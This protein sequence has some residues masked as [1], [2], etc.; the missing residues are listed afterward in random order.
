[1]KL[2]ALRCPACNHSLA[3]ENEHVVVSC[4]RCQA[5]VHISD[6]GLTQL[7][8]TYAAPRN[9]VQATDWLPF[10]VFEG[11]VNITRRTTQGGGSEQAAATRLW[12]EPRRL[13]VPAWELLLNQAQSIGSDMIQRQPSFQPAP[14]PAEARLTPVT[15]APQDALNVL[16]FIVLAIEARRPDWLKSLDFDLKVDEPALW[17]LPARDGVV[18]ALK[19]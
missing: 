7:S 11:R 4:E 2:L 6:E 5:A 19:E 10:W 3:P 1:M 18:V 12:G 8:V 17:A 14:Q 9:E 16:E 13:Y 15:L